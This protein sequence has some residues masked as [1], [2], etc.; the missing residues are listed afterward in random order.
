[1]RVLIINLWPADGAVGHVSALAELLESEHGFR[2]DQVG[3]DR[4][5]LGGGRGLARAL[6][7]ILNDLNPDWVV[8]IGSPLLLLPPPGAERSRVQ[9]MLERCRIVYWEPDAWGRGKP[10]PRDLR[11]WMNRADVLLHVGGVPNIEEIASTSTQVRLAPHP[12]SH[13]HFRKEA[14]S[15]PP[16]ETT[17]SV[18]MV[19]GNVTRTVLPIPL[20]TGLDGGFERFRLAQIARNTFG[21]SDFRLHGTG[22]PSRWSSGP[23][24]Y[25]DQGRILRSA[26]VTI[27]WDHFTGYTEYTSDRLA[28]SLLAGRLHVTSRHPEMTWAPGQ[29]QGLFFADSPRSVVRMASHLRD[30]DTSQRYEL[31]LS[32]WEWA[33]HHMSTRH[34]ARYVVAN[35][36]PAS[37][38]SLVDPWRSLPPA[39][40][41]RSPR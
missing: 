41:G 37:D 8:L 35:A 5:S 26:A 40:A 17:R 38:P 29:A 11:F 22:W 36:M 19:G 32:A 28:I 33:R 4:D 34:W 25:A 31:G 16:M 20:V 1:M 18:A 13:L 21:S 30:M 15:A 39:R 14:D 2:V 7:G 27:N 12:Y 23:V 3:G 10:L 9:R 6:P 24:A